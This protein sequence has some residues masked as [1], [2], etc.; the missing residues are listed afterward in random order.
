MHYGLNKI[1]SNNGNLIACSSILYVALLAVRLCV[2]AHFV[3]DCIPIGQFLF[4][5]WY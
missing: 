3:S 4:C 5:D 2:V 1:E